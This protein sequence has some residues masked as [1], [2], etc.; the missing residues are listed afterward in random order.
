MFCLGN[1]L[2]QAA[3]KGRHSLHDIGFRLSAYPGAVDTL[4][5]SDMSLM[6]RHRVANLRKLFV[7]IPAGLNDILMR[8]SAGNTNPYGDVYT[9]RADLRALFP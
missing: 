3:G 4:T 5:A 8:F 2:L 1:V 6:F 7:R 9:L